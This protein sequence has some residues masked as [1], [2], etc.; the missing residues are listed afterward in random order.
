MDKKSFIDHVYSIKKRFLSM[1][2]A[3]NAG[4]IACSLS[5]AEILTFLRFFWM[6]EPDTLIVSKGHTAAGLYSVLAEAGMITEED[7]KTFYKD[8][9]YLG[10]HP[11]VNRIKGIPFAT[12]SLG[13]GLSISAGR[14][15]ASKLKKEKR[16]FFCITSDGELDEGSTWEAAL[17]ISHHKLNNL[18]WLIDRNNI[19]GFGRTEEVMALEPLATKLKAF[20]FNVIEADGHSYESLTAA[21]KSCSSEMPNVVICK[22][23]KG[24]GVS[25]MENTVDWHY[26]PMNDEQ[27]QK[28][29]AELAAWRSSYEK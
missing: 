2:K 17:F 7:I 6:D 25:F 4:H 26:L 1:Y 21:K 9:T 11:P 24:Q 29:L 8:G 16:L 19:Q 27:Y 12:G 5:C 3:A 13:H 14:A 23:A 22:T 18:I 20:N 15:F 28:A 10:A